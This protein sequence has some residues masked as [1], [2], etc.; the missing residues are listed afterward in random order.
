MNEH[1]GLIDIAEPTAKRE[2]DTSMMIMIR[3]MAKD[4]PIVA[5]ILAIV[6][7]LGLPTGMGFLGVQSGASSVLDK[8]QDHEVRIT[9]AERDIVGLREAQKEHRDTMQEVRDHMI[10]Q[11]EQIS[12][13][14]R[15]IAEIKAAR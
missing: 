3:E 1:S 11:T 13:I 8:V 2:G 7:G 12:T 6:F 15:D 4:H 5:V 9:G 10:R 14:Q